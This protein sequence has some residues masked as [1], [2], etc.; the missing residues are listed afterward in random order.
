MSSHSKA[1]QG[2]ARLHD[3]LAGRLIVQDA[4][5]THLVIVDEQPE[6]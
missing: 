5:Q 4:V 6:S 3:M 2:V 1:K